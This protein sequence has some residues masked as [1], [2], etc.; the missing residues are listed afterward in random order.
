MKLYDLGGGKRFCLIESCTGRNSHLLVLSANNQDSQEWAVEEAGS[1]EN[2]TRHFEG[3][4][5]YL[6]HRCVLPGSA[7]IGSCSQAPG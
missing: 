3:G 2:N 5:S 7:L 4:R 6:D 1:S